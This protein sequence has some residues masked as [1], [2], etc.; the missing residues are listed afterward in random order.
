MTTVSKKHDSGQLFA[1][2]KAREITGFEI[3]N[4]L[5]A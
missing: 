4:R 5:S 3:L 1:A 2:R